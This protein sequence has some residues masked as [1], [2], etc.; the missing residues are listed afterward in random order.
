MSVAIPYQEL[1]L[2]SIRN[3]KMMTRSRIVDLMMKSGKASAPN[4]VTVRAPKA[5]TDL[6]IANGTDTDEFVTAA[7]TANTDN[8][9]INSALANNRYFGV[10]GI[11]VRHI[12]P[13][14][15][16][17]EVL[18]RIGTGGANV[19]ANLDLQAGYAYRDWCWFLDD[20]VI[21]QP[22]DTVYVT[23]GVAVTSGAG[24]V[25]VVPMGYIAE[26]AGQLVM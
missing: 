9:Y 7:L 14:P 20:P 4:Q 3:A 11:S 16:I 17:H 19:L 5:N 12:N 21:Y 13:R 1:T 26:P 23:L 25:W 22:T 18:L 8:V 6:G 2:D 15:P 24:T 10:Y